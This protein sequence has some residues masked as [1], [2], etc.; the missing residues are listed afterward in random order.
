MADSH[1]VRDKVIGG[2]I[3]AAIISLT[4]YFL[5]GGWG[6]VFHGVYFV[7]HWLWLWIVG[8]I[9]VAR[10]ILGILIIMAVGFVAAIG[11]FIFE[12]SGG[13]DHQIKTLKYTEGD[14]FGIHW[15]WR[16]GHDGIQGLA[17]FCPDCDLQ[18]YPRPRGYTV[19]PER[20]PV[21][22]RCDDCQRNLYE[23]DYTHLQVEDLV[24]RKIQQKIREYERKPD[25]A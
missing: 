11:F 8:D 17:S 14:F 13:V 10:W 3:L 18:V 2:L 15:R 21:V 19:L 25:A 24:T 9:S 12:S 23:S 5:P 6:A 7:F 4:I 22:Y 20:A 16:Y 1:P